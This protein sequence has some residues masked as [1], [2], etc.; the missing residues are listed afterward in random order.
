MFAK[1]YPADDPSIPANAASAICIHRRIHTTT[2]IDVTSRMRIGRK[3]KGK[4]NHNQHGAPTTPANLG[5]N[6]WVVDANANDRYW[7]KHNL[8]LILWKEKVKNEMDES[9]AATVKCQIRK[10]NELRLDNTNTNNNKNNNND[11]TNNKSNKTPV[12]N[13]INN[14]NNKHFI[15][16]YFLVSFK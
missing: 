14:N 11:D 5:G 16:L 12:N 6:Q 9:L 7:G 13:N 10:N 3:W 15:I 8:F 1:L 2:Q 4:K